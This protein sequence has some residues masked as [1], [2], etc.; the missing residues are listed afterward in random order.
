MAQRATVRLAKELAIVDDSEQRVDAGA[1][2]LVQHFQ[3]P[4]ADTDID[5]LAILTRVDRDA[6]H[7]AAAQ[8][9]ASRAA[10]TAH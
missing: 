5:G 7:R 9:A 1:A 8:A 4:L 3:E 6:I 10:A 2:A